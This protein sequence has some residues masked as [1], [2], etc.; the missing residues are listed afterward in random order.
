MTPLDIRWI[1]PPDHAPAGSIAVRFE[2]SAEDVPHIKRIFENMGFAVSP[3]GSAFATQ[4]TT[5][6]TVRGLERAGYR[7]NYASGEAA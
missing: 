1:A 3:S 7:L 4:I 6:D 2:A 5:G